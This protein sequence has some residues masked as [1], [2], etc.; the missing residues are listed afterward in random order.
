[1]VCWHASLSVREAIAMIKAPSAVTPSVAPLRSVPFL[2]PPGTAVLT[3]RQRNQL[4]RIGTRIRLTPR[5]IAYHEG[6]AADSAFI[7]IE[8][9]VKAYRDMPSGRRAVCAFLFSRD[10]FGLAERGRYVNSTQAITPVTLLRLPMREL[11]SVLKHDG[12][13]QFEFLTKIMHELR[14]AQRR[15]TL[16]TRRDAPGR[17]AMFLVMMNGRLS[18]GVRPS[19]VV[20]LP[21]SRSD[22]AGYLGLSLESVS[23][24]SAVLQH[25]MLVKF[26]GRHA[27]RII[28][29]DGLTRLAVTV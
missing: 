25:R 1:M 17:L 2:M 12:D 24:A 14:E 18:A 19:H 10:L 8:G 7:V 23:R 3:E 13:L 16:I 4:L 5:T 22:I 21:M 20:P 9:A 15:A 6:A 26:E 11:A 27:V 28:N 29:P